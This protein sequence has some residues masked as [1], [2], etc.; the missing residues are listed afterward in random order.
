MQQLLKEVQNSVHLGNF[1]L[2]TLAQVFVVS[3][4]LTACDVPVC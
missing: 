3:L 2:S 4:T 1:L